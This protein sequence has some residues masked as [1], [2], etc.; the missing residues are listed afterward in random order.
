[1]CSFVGN[2]LTVQF[3]PNSAYVAV[4]VFDARVVILDQ[5]FERARIVAE[6]LGVADLVVGAGNGAGLAGITAT[7]LVEGGWNRNP[8]AIEVIDEIF[9]PVKRRMRCVE[10]EE[11]AEGF[12]ARLLE[13]FDCFA[14]EKRVDV[15]ALVELRRTVVAPHA[16]GDSR[17]I[18]VGLADE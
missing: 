7:I 9:R 3:L 10:P 12:V 4:V 11:E 17:A 18:V 2:L 5:L 15:F 16:F 13:P 14:G 8:N 6:D 1:E